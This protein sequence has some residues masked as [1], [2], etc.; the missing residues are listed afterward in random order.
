MYPLLWI[1]N[2][3]GYYILSGEITSGEI[4]NLG[5]VRAGALITSVLINFIKLK[6]LTQLTQKI[7][8]C[9]LGI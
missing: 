6:N 7:R 5:E 1:F 4:N 3:M 2:G 9:F 8:I